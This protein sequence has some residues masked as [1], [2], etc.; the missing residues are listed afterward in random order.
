MVLS[1]WKWMK[2]SRTICFWILRV[3][4]D[5]VMF[6][7]G[8]CGFTNT[9]STNSFKEKEIRFPHIA[10]QVEHQTECHQHSKQ[11]TTMAHLESVHSVLCHYFSLCWILSQSSDF[12][13]YICFQ[14]ESPSS[15]GFAHWHSLSIES[16][17]PFWKPALKS[18]FEATVVQS[19]SYSFSPEAPRL[20]P[21]G[22]DT[23]SEWSLLADL[24]RS[25]RRK[26]GPV[27]E[28]HWMVV[29]HNRI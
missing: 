27:W 12:L 8:C 28:Q 9:Q 19:T 17:L 2:L 15:P 23:N 1:S 13:R 20:W 10:V 25:L 22:E 6:K 26:Q 7:D 4:E 16:V 5:E 3:C 21:S 24:R 14:T 18:L 11:I 29:V